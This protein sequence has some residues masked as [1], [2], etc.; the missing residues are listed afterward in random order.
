MIFEGRDY[1]KK[2]GNIRLAPQ[3]GGVGTSI[4]SKEERKYPIKAS[5][6][7]E[8]IT[9]TR[10]I[11]PPSWKALFIPEEINEENEWFSLSRKFQMSG[12]ELI[13]TEKTVTNNEDVPPEEYKK[14]RGIMLELNRRTRSQAV[15][16]Q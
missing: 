12:N 14:Y 10:L 3:W 15:F 1:L 9:E 11:L 7:S 13:Y 4:V 5:L 8:K 6:P 16:S 2:A